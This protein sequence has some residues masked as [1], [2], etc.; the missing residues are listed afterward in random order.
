MHVTRPSRALL[1][2]TRDIWISENGSVPEGNDNGEV[3]NIWE[4]PLDCTKFM[5]GK[6]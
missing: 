2:G 3:Q 1:E 4:N 6:F 5:T